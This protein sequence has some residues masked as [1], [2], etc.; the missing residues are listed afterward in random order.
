M[1]NFTDSN[2]KG[3]KL[4]LQNQKSE[5]DFYIHLAI[6]PH[7]KSPDRNGMDDRKNNWNRFYWISLNWTTI[8]SDSF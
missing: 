5:D 8:Q 1:R 7:K 3:A 2:P 6:G 4:S